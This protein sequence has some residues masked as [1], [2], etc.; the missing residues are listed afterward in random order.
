[1]GKQG[2]QAQ[3][4][5]GKKVQGKQARKYGA[6]KA[7]KTGKQGTGRRLDRVSRELSRLDFLAMVRPQVKSVISALRV[8][9]ADFRVVLVQNISF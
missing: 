5:Q 8:V 3:G 6:D 9:A 7:S 1:M 2:K 4:R